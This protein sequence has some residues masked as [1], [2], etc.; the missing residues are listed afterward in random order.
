MFSNGAKQKSRTDMSI[1]HSVGLLVGTCSTGDDEGALVGD[2]LGDAVGPPVGDSEGV[3][4]GDPVGDAVGGAVGTAVGDEVGEAVGNAVGDA[5]GEAVG[6]AVGFEEGDS[7]V[8]HSVQHSQ[9]CSPQSTLRVSNP[10]NLHTPPG[11]SPS[12][13]LFPRVR[14]SKS[15]KS[16]RLSGNHP[17]KRLSFKANVAGAKRWG[18]L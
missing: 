9:P 5:V 3:A 15:F 14:I 8:A 4:V 2:L 6:E 13:L 18:K 1:A 11:N 10:F 17:V 7:V 16:S 12:K